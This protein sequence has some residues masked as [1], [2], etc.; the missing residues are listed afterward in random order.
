MM[1]EKIKHSTT[2][3]TVRLQ[4]D[5]FETLEFRILR[6]LRRIIRAVDIHSRKLNIEFKITAPQKICLYWLARQGRMTLSEL[7]K[8]VSLGVSTV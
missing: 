3:E 2:P 7:A 6:S 8:K 5:F 4:D 1:K